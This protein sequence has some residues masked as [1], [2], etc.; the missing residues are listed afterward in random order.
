MQFGRIE[1]G[2]LV[3]GQSRTPLP[4]EL[5]NNLSYP[6][7]ADLVR[8]FP[9]GDPAKFVITIEHVR[10]GDF[11]EKPAHKVDITR[12]FYMGAFEVT[13]K[14]YEMFDPSHRALRGKNAFSKADDEAVVFVSWHDAKAFCATGS[15]RRKA[16][17]TGCLQRPNGNTPAAREPRLISGRATPCRRFFTRTLNEPLSMSRMTLCR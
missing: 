16:D 12:P 7:R 2:S 1:P 9:Q 10:N 15:R 4:D 11:D 5:T 6:K 8:K 14:Q 3:M 13:N 17:L